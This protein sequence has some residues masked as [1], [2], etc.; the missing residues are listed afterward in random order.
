MLLQSNNLNDF[1]P[2]SPRGLRQWLRD[3]TQYPLEDFNPRS[4]RGL[5]PSRKTLSKKWSIF[6]STQPKR[7]ATKIKA[8]YNHMMIFQSTQPE[9]AAT[10][11][12]AI[13]LFYLLFQSTQPEWAATAR[14]ILYALAGTYFNPR[15]P[16]GLRQ[17]P[18]PRYSGRCKHFNPRSPSGLRLP[19]GY[20]KDTTKQFQSTQPEWAATIIG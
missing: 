19:K 1:N 12:P 11:N 18:P 17:L 5:R 2:R 6:Q 3:K 14:L 9:W 10:S 15:S 8:K 20:N 16:S 13:R 7:A 4:P